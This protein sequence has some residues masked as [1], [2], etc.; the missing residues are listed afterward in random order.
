MSY[1]SSSVLTRH[2]RQSLTEDGAL[3]AESTS[4]IR[5]SRSAY[6]SSD[7][8]SVV[9]LPA[10][11]E[12]IETLEWMG[13]TSEKAKQLFD[14][15]QL[16]QNEE[17]DFWRTIEQS[18]VSGY[19]AVH[20]T[21]D[22]PG[23]IASMGLSRAFRKRIVAP[24]FN[25]IRQTQSAK[26]WVEETL[27]TM[28]RFLIQLPNDILAKKVGQAGFEPAQGKGHSSQV[29]QKAAEQPTHLHE[30]HKASPCTGW[31]NYTIS[32]RSS[33]GFTPCYQSRRHSNENFVGEATKQTTN[34]LHVCW[35]R[36]VLF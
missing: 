1:T 8:D 22:W 28:F 27:G 31:G 11:V 33:C 4:F 12:S 18:V 14:S 19:D 20:V 13:F 32:R 34:R 30:Y 36:Y 3:L 17:A 23:A 24:E 10:Q 5:L 35:L 21:D 7:D 26:Y 25:E 15:W 29:K 9:E 6:S 16:S 2:A